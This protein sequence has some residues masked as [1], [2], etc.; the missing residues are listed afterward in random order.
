M[1]GGVLDGRPSH[2]GGAGGR[3]GGDSA[4]LYR[5]GGSTVDD[6]G[7]RGVEPKYVTALVRDVKYIFMDVDGV[8]FEIWMT[9]WICFLWW[10][11][12]RV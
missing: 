11:D 1:L 12:G 9:R 7:P 10:A 6:S 3:S 2:G 4:G 8:P 5:R